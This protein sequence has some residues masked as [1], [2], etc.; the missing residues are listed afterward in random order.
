MVRGEFERFW[1]I[2]A[3]RGIAI[4]MMIT[5]HAVYDL[6]Y[7]GAFG[8]DAGE[9]HWRLLA[10]STAVLFITLVG[11]SMTL[12]YHKATTGPG[13]S[14]FFKFLKRGLKISSWGLL[15][16]LLTWLFI[17]E[18]YIL[19]G[20]LHLIGLAL[21]LGYPLLRHSRANLP[22]AIAFISLGLYLQTFEVDFRWLM[23]LG[24]VP[25][26]LVTVDYFPLLPWFGLVCLGIYL[27]NTFYPE[28]TRSFELPDLSNFGIVSFLS[29]LG[30]NSLI[31]YLL[32]QP[33]LLTILYI[34]GIIDPGFLP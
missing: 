1:E 16:T 34:A 12:S 30:R 29:H 18:A 28:H 3:V 27:G 21:I 23:W 32:H 24:L 17:P 31:V 9:F 19:F 13:V 22:L 6:Y 5:F 15:I 26:S 10:R 4:I 25:G 8:L 2:D 7:F 11:A 14:P 20:I 33:I